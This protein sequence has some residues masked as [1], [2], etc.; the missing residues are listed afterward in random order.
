MTRVVYMLMLL[1]MISMTGCASMMHPPSISQHPGV[2]V[3]PKP[4]IQEKDDL[5]WADYYK[6]Q[7]DAYEGHVM[8]PSDQYPESAKRG[9]YMAKKDWETKYAKAVQDQQNQ[10]ILALVGLGVLG[11]VLSMAPILAL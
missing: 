11:F 9:F 3:V 10:R 7:Y 1:G 6:D 8:P 5:V 2:A 4:S